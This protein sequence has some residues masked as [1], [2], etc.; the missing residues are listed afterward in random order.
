M[1]E[2]Y[3]MRVSPDGQVSQTRI[4][5]DQERKSKMDEIMKQIDD[6]DAPLAPIKRMIAMEI[7][8]IGKEMITCGGELNTMAA[9][10]TMR[11]K[12]LSEQVKALRELGKELMESDVL[13][14]KDFLNFEGPKLAYVLEEY[15]QGAVDTLK[16]I[17]IDDGTVQQFLRQ[18]RDLMMENELRIRRT[19]EKIEFN[20]VEKDKK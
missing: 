6:A 1:A 16:K 13:S 4:P 9:I 2:E 14:K 17:G 12:A 19:T 8:N 15:R 18:W 20:T 10:D 7:A 11:V 5:S 3:V